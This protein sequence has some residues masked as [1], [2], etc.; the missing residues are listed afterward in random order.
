MQWAYLENTL[1]IFVCKGTAVAISYQS[2]FFIVFDSHARD[3]HGLC[4][5]NGTSVIILKETLGE[6]C[7]HLRKSVRCDADK[8]I[9]Q[10]DLHVINIIKTSEHSIKYNLKASELHICQISNNSDFE[11]TVSV[12]SFASKS[13]NTSKIQLID[14]PFLN[15]DP[16]N[17]ML[18]TK[19]NVKGQEKVF[20][21]PSFLKSVKI[22]AM[23]TS[24]QN[25][26]H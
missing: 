20:K 25:F 11:S 8:E 4:C 2:G 7:A 10:Y 15:L 18:L 23:I 13:V 3:N 12:E 14:L 21:K 9:E 16:K 1:C 24:N 22:I 5:V 6:L 26:I 17:R 19:R